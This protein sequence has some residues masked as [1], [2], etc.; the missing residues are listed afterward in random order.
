MH[1][2]S[3]GD[4][5]VHYIHVE[6][7]GCKVCPTFSA[8]SYRV[9]AFALRS[10]FQAPPPT[11]RVPFSASLPAGDEDP[12]RFRPAIR[13]IENICAHGLRST[14]ALA[15]P[16]VSPC[17]R[18]LHWYTASKPSPRSAEIHLT[19]G[20]LHALAHQRSQ[21]LRASPQRIRERLLRS[22]R[23]LIFLSR[24]DHYRR[25]PVLRHRLR[26]S[27]N[28]VSTSSLKRLL[29]SCN[30]HTPVDMFGR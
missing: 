9:R 12:S 16:A 15:L 30:C 27:Q 19:G 22:R 24:N 14:P 20:L 3:R 6:A 13:W 7:F 10:R 28:A 5:A 26:T 1:Q 8:S 18:K 25:L 21:I 4:E 2:R 11:A 17:L 23:A 29:A